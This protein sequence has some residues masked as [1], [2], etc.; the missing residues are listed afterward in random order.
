MCLVVARTNFDKKAAHGMSIFV[1]DTREHAGFRKGQN[2]RKIGQPLFDTA[3]LFFDDV[4]LPSSAI[5]GGIEAKD[6]GFYCLMDELVRE[7]LGNAIEATAALEFAFEVTRQYTK[8]RK[9]FG[10]SLGSKQVIR[11][12]MANIKTEV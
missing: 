1:V 12:E 7:R 10:S 4:R 9:T 6:R 5:L 8:E 3:E 11:H 2:L